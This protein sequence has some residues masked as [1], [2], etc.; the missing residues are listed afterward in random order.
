L[1]ESPG[2]GVS[3]VVGI[4]RYAGLGEVPDPDVQAAIRAAIAEW[5]RKF[6][7]GM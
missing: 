7:P 2:G 5:E 3:V 1:E 6:T 4:N